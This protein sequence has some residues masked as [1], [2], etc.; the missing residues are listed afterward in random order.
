V[1]IASSKITPE[2]Q[3][4]GRLAASSR[5]IVGAAGHLMETGTLVKAKRRGVVF[6][7]LQ[8]DGT[9]A[10]SGETPQVK[11]Q[12]ATRVTTA[13]LATG[14][15]DRQDFRFVLDQPRHDE[16]GKF[17]ADETS[18]RNDTPVNQKALDFLFAPS[19][20]ERYAVKHRNRRSVACPGL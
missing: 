17:H 18:M 14:D 20:P 15:C 1:S 9:H 7:D 16:S 2:D 5:V 12:Q 6:I 10:E 13:L 11:V 8:K 4:G 19:A 3:R